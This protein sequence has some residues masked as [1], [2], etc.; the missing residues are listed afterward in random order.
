MEKTKNSGFTIIVGKLHRRL[1]V[2]FLFN[3]LLLTAP[4]FAQEQEVLEQTRETFVD[5]GRPVLLETINIRVEG[6]SNKRILSNR[7]GVKAGQEFINLTKLRAI[8][9]DGFNKL[10]STGY[11]KKD[12][13]SYC[14]VRINNTNIKV[15]EHI[16]LEA[17]FKDAWTIYPI[18]YPNY[19]TAKGYGIKGRLK[20]DNFLG[21]LGD[22]TLRLD[23]LEGGPDIHSGFDISTINITPD[24]GIRGAFD[25]DRNVDDDGANWKMGFGMGATW[26]IKALQAKNVINM[27]YSAST[28]FGG[29]FGYT[30]EMT[31]HPYF[32]TSFSHGLNLDKTKTSWGGVLRDGYTLSL[33]NS[34]SFDSDPGNLDDSRAF[35]LEDIKLDFTMI[36]SR[37]YFD[38][39]NFKGRAGLGGAL[40]FKNGKYN[41]QGT[42]YDVASYN[43]G[44]RDNAL[45]GNVIAF[46]NM[47]M[48]ILVF[49]DQLLGDLLLEP[50]LDVSWAW[51]KDSNDFRLENAALGSGFEL[52]WIFHSLK[53]RF[54][55]GFDLANPELYT[56]GITT[57]FYF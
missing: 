6:L 9:D 36:L 34:Y 16:H 14:L 51:G 46:L 11:F 35:A 8:L 24:F 19:S 4:I 33:G 10:K 28:K 44:K 17:K 27:S 20:W 57:G 31:T 55:F 42:N 21:L 22:I 47:D 23:V 54:S 56:I 48:A 25:L 3:L 39:L 18:A 2:F 45:E 30:G 52:I 37:S 5:E 26:N 15:F 41:K 1:K 43:R 40:D 32:F 13:I 38:M 50:F 29:T 12:S 49:S 7:L 53:F